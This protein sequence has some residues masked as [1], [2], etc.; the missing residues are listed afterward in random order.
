[1]CRVSERSIIQGQVGY[2]RVDVEAESTLKQLPDWLD[3]RA[4]LR[5]A[6]SE[7]ERQRTEAVGELPLPEHSE[8]WK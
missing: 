8:A 3:S 4:I 5:A 2:I 6:L 1:M 7:Y